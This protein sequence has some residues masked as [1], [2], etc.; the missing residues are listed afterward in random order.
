MFIKYLDNNKF[1]IKYYTFDILKQYY[2]KYID[3]NATDDEILT[4]Y[5][6]FEIYNNFEDIYVEDEVYKKGYK[7]II[8]LI[9]YNNDEIL[10]ICEII[11]KKFNKCNIELLLD[12]N[13][14]LDNKNFNIIYDNYDIKK[15]FEDISYFLN[16]FI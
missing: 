14:Y 11:N 8:D 5:S 9:L 16:N 7:I 13:T 1:I 6:Y 4:E 15:S 12:T 10:N 3:K 2:I